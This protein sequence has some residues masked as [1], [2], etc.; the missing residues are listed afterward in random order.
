MLNLGLEGNA[1]RQKSLDGSEQGYV[2]SACN[3][4]TLQTSHHQFTLM[5]RSLDFELDLQEFC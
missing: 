4:S 5:D 3:G 2:W 1:K